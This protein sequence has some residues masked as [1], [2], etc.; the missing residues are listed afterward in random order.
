LIDVYIP[1][2]TF[3]A[4]H[5]GKVLKQLAEAFL[6]WTDS[7][8]LPIARDN[9]M[10]YLHT[11]PAAHVTAG[12][13]PAMFVRIDVK[14]PEDVLSTIERRQGFIA[15]ATEIV[16]ALSAG[17]H[18]AEHTWVTISNTVDGGWGLAGHGITNAEIN[19]L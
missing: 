14:V 19:E 18:V 17:G 11:L 9:T 1:E 3:P 16:T 8:E 7:A 2:G 10:A 13:K 12:G 15:D 5:A 6:K 4:E